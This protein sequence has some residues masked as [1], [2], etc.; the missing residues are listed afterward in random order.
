MT[1]P[2]TD[3]LNNTRVIFF[4]SPLVD[5]PPSFF[6]GS[7]QRKH[8]LSLLMLDLMRTDDTTVSAIIRDYSGGVLAAS[9]SFVPHLVDA[10]MVEAYAKEGLMNASP[11]YRMQSINHP[12]ELHGSCPNYEG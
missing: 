2:I 11:T 12:I 5:F 6:L 3:F 1:F 9:H 8:I 7:E 4:H 10:P